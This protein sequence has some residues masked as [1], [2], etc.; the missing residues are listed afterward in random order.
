MK[1]VFYSAPIQ[2]PR[3]GKAADQ[4]IRTGIQQLNR[5]ALELWQ[6]A[7]LI[8]SSEPG[9]LT[10][11][12]LDSARRRGLAAGRRILS[13]SFKG[14]ARVAYFRTLTGAGLHADPKTIASA[15]DCVW[16]LEDRYGLADSYLR[17]VADTALQY[18]AECVLCPNPLRRD[19][20][21]AVFLPSYRAALISLSAIEDP[22]VV[23]GRRVHLD[24]IPDAE[25]KQALR[26]VLRE[27][28]KLIDALMNRVAQLI[29][30][31][32]ILRDLNTDTCAE[33]DPCL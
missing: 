1:P 27:N 21:E 3:P 28:R 18:R 19:R 32:E 17:A 25:R 6:A 12:D 31:A 22:G 30:N 29:K 11:S 5:R 9:L 10:A 33:I 24:R 16:L 14:K 4:E 2:L 23:I 20:L 8:A 15:A 26:A 13:G 7:A